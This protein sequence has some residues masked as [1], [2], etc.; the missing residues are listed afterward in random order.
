MIEIPIGKGLFAIVDDCDRDLLLIG[1]FLVG[2]KG[3]IH[4]RIN[5]KK[6]QLSREIA[7]RMGLSL[8]MQIDHE[9]RNKLNNQRSNLREATNGQNR[10]NSCV[11]KNSKTQVKGVEKDINNRFRAKMSF[12]GKRI[13]L[14]TFDSVE[15]ASEAYKAGVRDHFDDFAP[16]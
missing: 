7:R 11:Q 2:N 5:G 9:D 8:S 1:W 15:E 10:V 16:K 6:T 13:S 3:Q 4:G 14:G 12:Q